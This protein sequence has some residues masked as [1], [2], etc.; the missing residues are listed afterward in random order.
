MKVKSAMLLILFYSTSSFAQLDLA[1]FTMTNNT[2]PAFILVE[3]TPT[4]IYTPTN[5]K[6][7]AIHALDNFGKSL[8]VEV[9][10]YY[11]IGKERTDRSYFKYIG[12][13]KND[14]NTITQHPF[15]GLNT[16]TLSFA[17]VDKEFRGFTES[18]K[19]Y[20]VGLRT[21]ILRFYDKQ[22]VINNVE[23]L[24]EAMFQ[25]P[26]PPLEVIEAGDE[27]IKKFYADNAIL[28]DDLLEPFKKTIKPLFKVDGAFGYSAIFKENNIN[29]GTA[30][31]FGAWITAEGSFILNEGSENKFNNYVNFLLVA[32]YIDDG[33]NRDLNNIYFTKT[34]TD[35][36]GKIDLE[37]GRFGFGYE[38]IARSG[39]NN[40]ERSVGNVRFTLTNNI[41]IIGGFGKDFAK[42]DNLVTTIGLN[43]GFNFGNTETS[44]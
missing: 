19:S 38:F 42:T 5:V 8:S 22:K 25:I 17:Y 32:R 15:S 2:S 37:F 6:A 26:T 41:S 24:Q 20:S 43:W 28:I 27:A 44:F 16:T 1:D 3:E 23:Q 30:N 31:R 11:F 29:S 35:V 4:E 39:N 7:L 9:A 36:G 40:G 33:F 34:Y 10:P 12:V 21:T 18:H 14:D 13:V